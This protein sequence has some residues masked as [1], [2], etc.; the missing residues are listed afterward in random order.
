M[1]FIRF[2]FPSS[3]EQLAKLN[4]SP[5]KDLQSPFPNRPNTKVYEPFW[6]DVWQEAKLFSASSNFSSFNSNFSMVLPPPNITGNLHMGHALTVAV[7]DA[8][9]R[10]Q[11]LKNPQCNAVFV[12]GYDHAGIGMFSVLDK[13][14]LSRSNKRISDYS[15]EEFD[16]I[17]TKWKEERIASIREQLKLLGASLDF[18]QEQ[19]TL[20]NQMCRSVREAFIRLFESGLIYRENA[21]VNWCYHLNS[22]IS[23]IE[24]DWIAV[25]N[26]RSLEFAGNQMTVGVLYTVSLKLADSPDEI[27]VATTRPNTIA[28]DVAVAVHPSDSRYAH[29]IGRAAINPLTDRRMP[30][31]ADESVSPEFGTGAVKITPAC[32]PIDFQIAQTHRLDPI[33]IF[34]LNGNLAVADLNEECR[35]LNGLNRF[36]LNEEVI[37]ILRNKNQLKSEAEHKTKLPVC[38]KSGDLIEYRVLPQWYLSVEKANEFIKEQL[39]SN[40]IELMPSNHKNTLLDWIKYERPWCISRQIQWGHQLPVYRFVSN[41]QSERWVAANSLEEAKR[42]FEERFKGEQYLS[43]EQERDVLDTWFSSSLIPF[44]YFGWPENTE[45]LKNFYPLSLMETG[46]DIL[47]FWVHKM[48]IAGY[49]L[50]GQLPFRRV[51]LHGMVV[52]GNGKKMSKSL[53]NV[54][55]PVDFINGATLKEL[56]QRLRQSCEDGYLTEAQLKSALKGQKE[57]FPKGLLL[58]STDGLRLCFYEHDPKFEVLKMDAAYITKNRNMINKIWQS[59]NFL[60]F[61]RQKLEQEQQ[62][63]LSLAPAFDAIEQ[64]QLRQEDRW[65]LSGL[66]RFV[67]NSKSAYESYDLNNVYH[68]FTQ[69]FL[70]SYCDVYMELIKPSIYDEDNR[71]VKLMRFSI[72]KHCL[73]TLFS[74]MHPLVPFITEELYQKL[75]YLNCEIGG[76]DYAYRSVLVSAYPNVEQL[77]RFVDV[78]L[79]DQMKVAIAIASKMRWINSILQENK[80]P[81]ESLNFR[82]QST[83]DVLLDFLDSFDKQLKQLGRNANI[84]IDFNPPFLLD[85][86]ESTE[87]VVDRSVILKVNDKLQIIVDTSDFDLA[88]LFRNVIE[89]SFEKKMKN[90]LETKR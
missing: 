6:Y 56:Q 69:F 11:K 8:I 22:T 4:L 38:S 90:Q 40:E 18:S 20:S 24:V 37:K 48:L 87:Y 23:D 82:I 28:G 52:D 13:L 35:H 57:L 42:K 44:G 60:L 64:R 32:S 50:T 68:S 16:Q 81:K 14:S 75:R 61:I 7:E 15:K 45:H 80:F 77:K 85:D 84:E 73:S 58:N 5:L 19:F 72:L 29:L 89:A 31:I 9:M 66:A 76:E 12:P 26:S 71:P 3:S 55:D 49:Y 36:A 2:I 78:D 10:Y 54:L 39:E 86:G 70:Y 83:D 47:K 62:V 79:E 1:N 34:D 43:V 74:T 21:I 88:G 59:F 17:T 27:A 25:D 41:D 63:D 46:H 65:I 33:E 67:A 53:G 51:L 30:I